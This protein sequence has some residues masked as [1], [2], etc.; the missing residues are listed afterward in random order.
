MGIKHPLSGGGPK[1]L[2]WFIRWFYRHFF[3]ADLIIGVD[4][5]GVIE[6]AAISK[7]KGIP[8]GYISYEIFFESETSVQFKQP[9]REACRHILFAVC[10][11]PERSKLLVRENHIGAEKIIQIP[12]AGRKVQ[13]GEKN[14][15]LHDALGIDRKKHIALFVGSI[16]PWTKAEEILGAAHGW[17]DD[18]VLVVHPRYGRSLHV[19]R[20]QWKY[21]KSNNIYFSLTPGSRCRDI[22]TMI[23]SADLGIALYRPVAGNIYTND[24]IR[25]LGLASGKI[26]CYLQNGVPVVVNEIGAFAERIRTCRLGCVVGD[27]I[28][29]PS[30]SEIEQWREHCYQFFENTLDL[31]KTIQPLLRTI[32]RLCKKGTGEMVISK[33]RTT[34]GTDSSRP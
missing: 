31:D 22:A 32:N 4:R 34:A 14:F 33:Q 5:D 1:G 3:S 28:T 13:R 15:S 24:N 18:W 16:A 25:Y 12:V 27:D 26:S 20:L 17:P 2:R 11:D 6:A 10:Q 23:Q 21:R 29:L 19:M 30:M 9:E 7:M 8:C